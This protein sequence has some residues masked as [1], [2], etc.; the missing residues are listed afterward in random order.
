MVG[1]IIG[2]K[3]Q[4]LEKIREL[5]PGEGNS[6]LNDTEGQEWGNTRW[7]QYQ[8]SPA[9]TVFFLSIF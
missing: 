3:G 8:A 2:P 9:V 6:F 7:K 5:A 1:V 4:T